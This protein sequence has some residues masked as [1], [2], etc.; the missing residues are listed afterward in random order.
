MDNTNLVE[1]DLHSRQKIDFESEDGI[2]SSNVD[3]KSLHSKI[4]E[5]AIPKSKRTIQMRVG[6]TG[7]IL[8][9]LQSM[10]LEDP[11]FVSAMQADEDDMITNI[12]WADGR[13]MTDYFYFGD[14]V[15]F[16]TTYEKNNEC[17][18]FTMFLG[19]NHH[20]QTIIFGAAL[21]YDET[22]ETFAWLFDTFA[23]TMLGKK[24]KTILT[25][26]DAA[27]EKPLES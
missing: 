25:D 11:A 16:D 15:S 10:Q 20:K 18:P 12:F 8:E 9:Y 24:P 5:E 6:D 26:Q 4:D 19:V 23:K 3:I 21:L 2:L 1:N 7:G 17:R 13:M 27:K 22:T 14:V